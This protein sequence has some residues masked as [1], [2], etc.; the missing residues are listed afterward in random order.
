MNF[1]PVQLHGVKKSWPVP[2]LFLAWPLPGSVRTFRALFLA[3]SWPL[4]GLSVQTLE[5]PKISPSSLL[6]KCVDFLLWKCEFWT[7][8]FPPPPFTFTFTS[9]SPPQISPQKGGFWC[10]REGRCL[11]R[12]SAVSGVHRVVKRRAVQGG[13]PGNHCGT[14][15]ER[16]EGGQTKTPLVSREGSNQTHLVLTVGSEPSIWLE[17]ATD[18]SHLFLADSGAFVRSTFANAT[19]AIWL[20]V[21]RLFL[22]SNSGDFVSQTGILLF[23]GTTHFHDLPFHSTRIFI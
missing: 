23:L 20:E 5:N 19:L 2:R 13:A 9:P 3:S 1:K 16:G 10:L 6:R 17:V 12:G 4:S 14:G 15:N 7:L 21:S 22:Q 8:P 11:P 18:F